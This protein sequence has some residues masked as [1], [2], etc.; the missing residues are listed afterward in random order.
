[1]GRQPA[2]GPGPHPAGAVDHLDLE[3][4]GEAAYQ[5]HHNLH[6][7]KI[8]VRCLAPADGLGI[9]DPT[10]RAAVGEADRPFPGA[11]G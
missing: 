2:G 3:Q 9:D 7:G 6:E 11:R 1:M 10:L 4:V 8:A 5:V